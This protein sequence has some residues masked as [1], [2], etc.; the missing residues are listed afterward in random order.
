MKR[1]DFWRL[2]AHLIAT[3]RGNLDRFTTALDKHLKTLSANEIEDFALVYAE[4]Q[5]EANTTSIL[6]AAYIIGCGASNDGFGDFRRWIVFQGETHFRNIIENPD[7]L[8]S[9]DQQSDPIEHW[10]S[11]YDPMSAYEEVTGKELSHFNVAVYPAAASDFDKPTILAKRYPTL[12]KRIQA[13]HAAQQ[14]LSDQ[15]QALFLDATLDRVEDHDGVARFMFSTGAEI[16]IRAYWEHYRTR[17]QITDETPCYDQ[18]PMLG[19]KVV[20]IMS[21]FFPSS[22]FMWFENRRK[23]SLR[24]DEHDCSDFDVFDNGTRID[25]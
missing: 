13:K 18:H 25:A 6:E 23:L 12:W 1:D 7:Y 17:Y 3:T 10:Y 4:L 5:N 9:Y 14:T 19:H 15:G 11:E 22:F 8:G 24:R 21:D 20:S 16:H 2:V